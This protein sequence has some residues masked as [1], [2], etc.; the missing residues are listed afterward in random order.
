MKED[1]W[2][3][4]RGVRR[5]G[6]CDEKGLLTAWP[7]GGPKLLWTAG[8]LGSG[9][10]SPII[11]GGTIYIT[12]DA[13]GDLRIFAL[14]ISGKTKWQSSNGKSWRGPYPGARAS[15]T[16]KDGRVYNMNAHGRVA[17][18]DAASGKELWAADVLERFD[19]RNITWAVAENL[20]IDGDR[21][22]VT[23]GGKKAVMAALDRRT[24]Q[25]V[26]SSG[27]L[28]FDRD[29][30]VEADGP[31]YASPILFEMAGRRLVV[32]CSTHHIFCVDAE[33][34][35]QLWTRPLKTVH[36]VI[37]M[38]PVLWRNAIF[39]T[40]PDSGGGRLLGLKNDGDAV[41][42]T[43]RWTAS[44]DTCHG[45]VIAV[46]G[47]LYGSWYRSY[48]GWGCVDAASGKVLCQTRNLAM[49]SAIWADGHL[50]CLSQQGVMAL[51]KVGAAGE[52]FKIVSRFNFAD[53][54]RNDVWAHPVI[55][56]GRMYLRY[57]ERLYCFDVRTGG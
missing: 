31:S 55:L 38:T 35:K 56:D 39:M 2:P 36:D 40:A 12:G 21:V 13:A 22:I 34:G 9:Y 24:G 30:W 15:C 27:P 49:G 46:D 47:F 26:W 43:E 57:H 37:A 51:V 54:R 29:G 23:P 48:N 16:F 6:I 42:V 18:L 20:L 32:G 1:G 45:G 17:C 7:E 53:G 19:G 25:T 44:I 52:P 4:W 50:Y 14:D 5:D 8:G 10:S 3:Q 28:M 33:T 41:R 11:T